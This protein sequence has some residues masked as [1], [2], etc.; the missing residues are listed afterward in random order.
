[1]RALAILLAIAL[2]M[3][4]ALAKPPAEPRRKPLYHVGTDVPAYT[5]MLTYPLEARLRHIQGRGLFVLFVQ[6]RTGSVRDVRIGRS[7][8]SKILDDAAVNNLKRWL[9]KPPLLRHIE[10]RHGSTATPGE[11]VFVV[12]VS[13]RL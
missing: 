9:Y 4:A 3:P 7:T 8:G 12:P 13:F 10:K 5:P 6:V 1:M 2:T 11:L